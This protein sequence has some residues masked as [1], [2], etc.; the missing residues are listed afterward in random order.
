[1]NEKLFAIVSTA[2]T[3]K[4]YL[5]EYCDER[6]VADLLR[7]LSALRERIMNGDAMG[8]LAVDNPLPVSTYRATI[9]V[10]D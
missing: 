8:I 5:H 7:E 3:L 2:E 10:S 1:M 6:K 4:G 9:P